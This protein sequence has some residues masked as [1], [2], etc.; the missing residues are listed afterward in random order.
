[1]VHK[2]RRK[3]ASYV[4][5]SICFRFNPPLSAGS[6]AIVDKVKKMKILT[7]LLRVWSVI[8]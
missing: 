7:I 5:A 3:F 2:K 6:M 4:H 8:I 1:M